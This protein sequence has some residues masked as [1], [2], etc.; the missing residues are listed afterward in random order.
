MTTA[1]TIEDI[2]VIDVDTH[3][4]EPLDLWTSR[5]PKHLKDRVP[6]VEE[7]NGVQQWVIE[8]DTVLFPTPGCCVIR[9]D[10]SKLRGGMS[11]DKYQD[12]IPAATDPHERLKWMDANGIQAQVIYPNLIGFAIDLFLGQVDDHE[13]R[14]FCVQAWNDYMGEV[15][16][17]GNGR[18]FPQALIPIWDQ[19]LAVKEAIRAHE[20]LGMTGLN[21]PSGPDAHG[22]P[23]LSHPS[24]DKLWAVAQERNMSINFHIGGGGV[25][26]ETWDMSP[27][28]QF[29]TL[30]TTAISSNVRCIINLI[31]S[32]LLDRFPRLNFVSVESGFGW[33]PFM[34]ELM[35]YQV[36]EN[37]VTEM[38]LRPTEYFRRQIH[39]SYWFEKTPKDAIEKIGIDN[40]MFETDFPHPTCL[41]PNIREHINS[42]LGEF[43]YED[44]RKILCEN[45]SKLYHIPLPENT[46]ALAAE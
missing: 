36:D 8:K 26:T 21:V 1:N 34:L 43:S 20:E 46:A 17:I 18:L 14:T 25:S 28:R 4:N 23:S 39:A 11:L 44:Q 22:L 42:S 7:V 31:F 15:Q 40:V 24:N 29:A 16:A 2:P 38:E 35:E 3:Y 45:A 32:G 9:E 41:Y 10:G 13:M 19:E 30:S 12:M 6:R 33:I 27:L 37:G 5:A